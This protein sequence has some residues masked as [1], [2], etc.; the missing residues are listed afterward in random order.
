MTFWRAAWRK[1]CLMHQEQ[2]EE[3]G[4]WSLSPHSDTPPLSPGIPAGGFE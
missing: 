2:D 4:W 1:L 3:Q